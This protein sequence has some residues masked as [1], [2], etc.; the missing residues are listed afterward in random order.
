MEYTTA[1]VAVSAASSPFWL[2]WLQSV[3]EVA[4]MVAPIVGVIWLVVQIAAKVREMS[5][6]DSSK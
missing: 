6:K 2:P 1:G 3:S 5:G 4:A